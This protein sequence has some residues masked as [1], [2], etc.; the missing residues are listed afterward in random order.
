VTPLASPLCIP[1]AVDPHTVE[2]ARARAPRWSALR[3]ERP[4]RPGPGLL[5][6]AWVVGRRDTSSRSRSACSSH[7]PSPGQSAVAT[8]LGSP[9]A[10]TKNVKAPVPAVISGPGLRHVS[11]RRRALPPAL[12]AK[13]EAPSGGPSVRPWSAARAACE[14]GRL[15]PVQKV[16]TEDS[17]CTRVLTSH[18]G[19]PTPSKLRPKMGVSR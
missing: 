17:H 16:L 18:R 15:D 2:R 12:G 10:T 9:P 3:D 8:Q 19:S 6:F 14:A 13:R 11:R 4:W 5:G 1:S 7:L